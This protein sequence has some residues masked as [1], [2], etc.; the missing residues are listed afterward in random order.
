MDTLLL[1]RLQFATTTS[2]H[3]LF[4]V[5]TLGLVTLLVGM[6]TAWV[7]T[8]NP[9]WERLTRYWGQ[10]YVINYVLGIATGIVMEFQ[11]GLNWSGLSRYVGNVFG[12]PLAIETLVAFFLESTFLGMWIFGWHRLGKGVH[13]ALLWGVAITAYASAFWIMV[14]N[15]WLQNPVG[16]EV[17]DGIAHLTDFGALLTNPSLGMAFGHVVSAAVLVGGMLMAAVSAW[18]L[19][20]RTPDFVL[21]RTSL[22]IGL[23]TSAFAITMVQGFGFAQFGPVG[24]VQPTKFGQGP[25][26]QALIAEWTARFGPGDYTPPVLANVGLG[27]MI[28]IGFTLGCV[29]FLL[30][31]L[32]R[33]WIIRLRFP[34]WLVLLALPLPFVAVI[35]GWIAREVGRQPWVAYGLLPTEQAVSPVGAPVMLTSLIGFSLLLGTLAVTNWVLLAR[36]AARGAADPALGRPPSPPN[37]SAHPEPALV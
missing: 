29:W 19:I 2:I 30:P 16:Y 1:A 27:F 22:R 12:A 20:R 5:V 34:L 11:F 6:Q 18:H 31:L 17:R 25:E 15:S 26:G 32:F 37:E 9:K 4:V 3:F 24:A 33:D 14:A 13:L 10:L 7:L 35:L 8:G 36:H 23:V 21:F 28:L